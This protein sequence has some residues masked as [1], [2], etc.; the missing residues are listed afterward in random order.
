LLRV[1]LV[2]PEGKN[3]IRDAV[4]KWAEITAWH[5]TLDAAAQWAISGQGEAP[6]VFF[7]HSNVPVSVPDP[8]EDRDWAIIEKLKGIRMSRPQSRILTVF[9]RERLKERDFLKKITALGIYDIH[10][11]TAFGEADIKDWLCRPRTFADVAEFLAPDV[12]S[13]KINVPDSRKAAPKAKPP[14]TPIKDILFSRFPR[15]PLLTLRKRKGNQGP[16]VLTE[17]GLISLNAAAID[18]LPAGAEALF[19]PSSWGVQ[20]VAK[21]RRDA[22][23]QAIPLIVTG[24]GGNEFLAAGADRC[25]EGITGGVIEEVLNLRKRLKELWSQANIDALTG[26]YGRAFWDVWLSEHLQGAKEG[27][28]FAVILIDLDNF[29]VLNDTEGHQAGDEVL[30]ELGSF[31]L[32][33]LRHSD[34]ACRYGGE[35]FILGCPRTGVMEAR[36][37]AER[38]RRSWEAARK[39][40]T[41]S[42]GVAV[43]DGGD[44][45]KQADLALYRA[46]QTG[47]NRACIYQNSGFE[48]AGVLAG[49][50]AAAPDAAGPDTEQDLGLIQAPPEGKTEAR[51][52]DQPVPTET[53]FPPQRVKP[54]FRHVPGGVHFTSN[55]LC[56]CSPWIPGDDTTALVMAV[57][58][59]LTGKGKEVVLID[60][61]FSQPRLA[62]RVG[63]PPEEMWRYD[64]RYTETPLGLTGQLFCFPLDPMSWHPAGGFQGSL[65][66]ILR[67][68]GDLADY[69]LVDAGDD[70]GLKVPGDQLLVVNSVTVDVIKAW[71]F[72]RPLEQGAAIGPEGYQFAP[73]GIQLLSEAGDAAVQA[74]AVLGCWA[75]V[76][77]CFEPKQ[78]IALR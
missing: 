4:K 73:Y 3:M 47:K 34:V 71:D 67:L 21:L 37:L 10:L 31:L 55:V 49:P 20:E 30:R 59:R 26:C 68:A 45:V 14:A 27:I 41:L 1:H 72:Y 18:A 17:E 28:G 65:H 24:K 44:V 78:G 70:P 75:P 32:V 56:I 46:K 39:R 76:R 64:W 66:T 7:I 13:E 48:E 69:I 12:P 57:A 19:L 38:L 9:H 60:A 35:E 25:V 63:L 16:A 6:D 40:P 8:K 53:G 33:I 58:E 62:G 43:Y 42:L 77:A 51:P 15:V 54:R 52:A 23:F 2:M 5:Y 11:V 61:A 29:K 36:A 50:E 74:E 22:R